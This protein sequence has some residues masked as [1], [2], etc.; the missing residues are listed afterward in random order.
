M[1]FHSEAIPRRQFCGRRPIVF[2]SRLWPGWVAVEPGAARKQSFSSYSLSA[3][4]LYLGLLSRARERALRK[5]PLHKSVKQPGRFARF[6]VNELTTILPLLYTRRHDYQ[7]S[8]AHFCN[9]PCQHLSRASSIAHPRW[10]ARCIAFN[11]KTPH[12]QKSR[13]DSLAG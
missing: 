3:F 8:C 4:G 6:I 7:I 10:V 1:P 12:A 5:S 9:R 13:S 2:V 11:G